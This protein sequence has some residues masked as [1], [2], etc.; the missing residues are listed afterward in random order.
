MFTPN[1]A[2]Y[3]GCDVGR[4]IFYDTENATVV[5]LHRKN[6]NTWYQRRYP[7]DSVSNILVPLPWD[8]NTPFQTKKYVPNQ[9]KSWFHNFLE[10][11]ST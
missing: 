7:A 11:L 3:A 8:L 9:T 6:D 4:V 1:Q 5:V 2:V 10:M